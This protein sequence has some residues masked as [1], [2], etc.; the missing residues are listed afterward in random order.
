[1]TS[2]RI[3]CTTTRPEMPCAH[4]AQ[5]EGSS[6]RQSTLIITTK[7]GGA[8]GMHSDITFCLPSEARYPFNTGICN[9]RSTTQIPMRFHLRRIAV[10]LSFRCVADFT[11]TRRAPKAAQQH[12]HEDIASL[13]QIILSPPNIK[14]LGVSAMSSKGSTVVC[15]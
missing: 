11:W 13:S 9:G 2:A 3:R 4:I 8:C 14:T 1:M 15:L 12:A 6:N 5:P 10:S 7:A